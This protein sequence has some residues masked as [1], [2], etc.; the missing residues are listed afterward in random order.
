M[1]FHFQLC[2]LVDGVPPTLAV[3]DPVSEKSS[4]WSVH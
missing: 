3:G 2:D 1:A 4:E